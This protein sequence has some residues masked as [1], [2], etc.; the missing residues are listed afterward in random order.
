VPVIDP[1]SICMHAAVC[2]KQGI[3]PADVVAEEEEETSI[4]QPGIRC[5]RV[6]FLAGSMQGKSRFSP[7]SAK[8]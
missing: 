6:A 5:S 2:F 1:Q 4:R 8:L 3:V 7:T